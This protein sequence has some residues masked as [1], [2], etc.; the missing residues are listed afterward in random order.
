MSESSI[1]RNLSPVEIQKYQQNRYPCFFLDLIEEAIPGESAKGFKNFTYNEWFFPA[2]FEDEPVVPG[3]IQ[4]ETLTQVFL[5]TFL[6][7]PENKGKKTGFLS[8]KNAD[9]KKKII[10]GNRLDIIAELN[11]YRRGIASGKAIGFVHGELACQ[12]ELVVAVPDTLN[13]FLP[14]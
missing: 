5:M 14:K 3:F 6:T 13:K 11:S 2:H 9:F 4:I 8:V 7:I 12:I 10:P 1:L